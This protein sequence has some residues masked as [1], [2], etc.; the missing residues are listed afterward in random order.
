MLS[1][2]RIVAFNHMA[3][4]RSQGRGPLIFRSANK[5]DHSILG[6]R[7]GPLFFRNSHIGQTFYAVLFGMRSS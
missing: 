7:L 4:S 2:A 1:V 5:K 3:A 6:S